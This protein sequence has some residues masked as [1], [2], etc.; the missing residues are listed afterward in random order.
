MRRW[1]ATVFLAALLSAAPGCS[2]WKATQLYKSG[3]E[4]IEAGETRRAITDL[5]EASELMPGSADIQNHLGIAYLQ[6]GSRV[7]ARNAFARAVALDCSD[8]AAKRN[9]TILDAELRR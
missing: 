2:T 1:T 4:A 7:E 9:L 3:T 5:E 6:A 8:P